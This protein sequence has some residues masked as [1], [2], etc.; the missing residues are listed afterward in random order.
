MW[1]HGNIKHERTKRDKTKPKQAKNLK[2][3][4]IKRNRK[5]KKTTKPLKTQANATGKM[6]NIKGFSSPWKV[7]PCWSGLCLN[8]KNRSGITQ[9]NLKDL[10]CNTQDCPQLHI[11]ITQFIF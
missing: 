7:L 4:K 2:K 9:S 8:E 3:K 6:G 10:H 5:I 11:A 1:I